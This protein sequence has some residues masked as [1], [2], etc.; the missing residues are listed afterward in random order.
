MFNEAFWFFYLVGMV[1]EFDFTVG[2]VCLVTLL[3]SV[4]TGLYGFVEDDKKAI[5]IA[6]RLLI[7]FL[8]AASIAILV[9]SKESLYA[10][11][12]QY[13]GEA[14]EVDETLIRLKGLLDEKLNGLAAEDSESD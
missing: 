9:P 2:F 14:T 11:A 5:K 1:E 7:V 10:G 12:A 8:S 4:F 13:V 6:R 3:G